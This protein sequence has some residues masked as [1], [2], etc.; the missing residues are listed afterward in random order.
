MRKVKIKFHGFLGDL[1][2]EVIEGSFETL[3]DVIMYLSH[4]YPKFKAPLDIGRYIIKIDGYESRESI[5]CP[6]YTDNI[7]I[8]PAS[9]FSK[10]SG[11]GT[12]I[13]GVAII[14][15]A[16]LTGGAAAAIAAGLSGALGTT[17]T[18][19]A[20]SSFAL[21]LGIAGG[22]MVLTGLLT[23]MTTPTIKNKGDHAAGDNKYLGTPGNTTAS[24][25][26]IPIGYGKFKVSGHFLSFNISSSSVVIGAPVE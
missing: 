2:P 12:I 8:R 3:H 22:L 25:T 18:A 23:Y 1:I 21:Q 19:A 4:N 10:S 13:V 5:Y 17:V 16:V 7:D 15:L 11:M 26:A 9:L 14:A 24:G 6:L 20:V